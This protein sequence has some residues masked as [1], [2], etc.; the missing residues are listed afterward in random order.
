L[1]QIENFRQFYGSTVHN[2]PYC[3]GWEC[4]NQPIAVIGGNQDSVDLAIELLLWSKDLVLCTN[5][6]LTCNRKTVETIRRLDIRVIETPISR[7]EGEGDKLER[8][9]FTD[10]NF[11][12]RTALFF[13][14]GQYQRSHL[15]EQLGCEFC[16]D[17]NCIQ[18]GENA[19]TNIP[20]VYA[21]GNASRGVQLVIAAAAEGMQAAFAINSALLDADA[22]SNVLRDHKPGQPTPPDRIKSGHEAVD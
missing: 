16:E 3:D 21:A 19:A 17:T 1:P 4:R 5:G 14:P 15:A 22:A 9:R 8:I 18:C 7:L 10:G 12:P 6:P 2:C 13:S 11:L 20:G